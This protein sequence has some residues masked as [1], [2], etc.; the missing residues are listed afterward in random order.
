VNAG[1]YDAPARGH[2]VPESVST[3]AELLRAHRRARGL[4]QTELAERAQLSERAISDIERSLK[5]PH[6]ATVRLLGEALALSPG[7]LDELEAARRARRQPLVALRS[8]AAG[9]DL[10]RAGTSFIGR[11]QLLAEVRSRIDPALA[12]CRLLTLT[13]PGG[14]GKTRLAFEAAGALR[15]RYADG[16]RHVELAAISDPRLVPSTIAQALG[17]AQDV[18]LL[19]IERLTRYLRDRQLLLILDNFEQV[20]GAA[21]DI[22][23]LLEACAEL[24]VLITSRVPLRLVAEQELAVPPL[25]LPDPPNRSS[26]VVEECESVRL[27]VDRAR[28]VNADFALTEDNAS[29]VA[30]ICRRLDGL[31]LAI[32]LAAARIRLLDPRAM[33][34]RLEHRLQ[35][36]SGGAR[37]APTRQQALRNTISW[38]YDLLD[39]R[40]QAVFR[41]LAAFVGGISLDA[42]QA[43]CAGPLAGAVGDILD[44]V[45]S[46]VA[47]NL[48]R[49]AAAVPGE[50]R[51]SVFETIREFG[52]EQLA[53]SGELEP[54][55]RRHAQYFLAL[56]E[57]AGRGLAGP[58]A[59]ASLDRLEL[60]HDNLRAALDWSLTSPGD[61]GETALRLASALAPFW[62]LASHFGEGSRW[63]VRALALAPDQSAVRMRALHGAGWL[64]TFQRDPATARTLLEESLAIANT[65]EDLWWQAWVLH[66]LGRVAYFEYD[67]NRA[68]ELG[69]HSLAIAEGLGDRWLVAW[70]L[71]LLGLA[72]YIASDYAAAT[73]FYDRCLEIRAELGHVVGIAI[74]LHIKGML[75]ERTG[76][77]QAALATYREALRVVRELN[78][79]WLLSTV[80]PHFAG[81]AAEH[82]PELAARLGGAVA[83]MSESAHTLPIP[84]T[85]SLFNA[86]IQL[87][88]RKLGE[89]TFAAA[90]TEGRGMSLD[91]AVAEALAVEVAAPNDRP[92]RLTAAEVEVLRG[93]AS[94]RTNRQIAAHLVVAVSTVDRHV[95]HIYQKLGRRGRAAATVFA[96]EHGLV[97]SDGIPLLTVDQKSR[98][99]GIDSPAGQA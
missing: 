73:D 59:R 40:E 3:F 64:A 41:H 35:W 28:A 21:I 4:T 53:W 92:A 87:A 14:T 54:A 74:V 80:L 23:E 13:G 96:L 34:A 10:P 25:A 60:E 15:D 95:T 29:A 48:V 86:G 7:Q 24:K 58:A 78:S 38:S 69:E 16:L 83:L 75:L 43:V 33:L 22:A 52:L 91:E 39:A 2:Q 93:L 94:G 98:L 56:A 90:W 6:S 68:R 71:H 66:A 62:W 70:A 37:D 51:V 82:Q 42:A 11:E 18:R 17:I 26:A 12:G 63:L 49:S 77:L 46:L 55:R 45:E 99:S 67:P 89:S 8:R 50:V 57:Q 5:T 44:P 30:E 36:L 76:K 9:H 84:L 81:L 79:A 61:G 27:F 32:E 85:E 97:Q 31:P 1:C 65:L 88:R 19:P 47:K 72:A 20:L